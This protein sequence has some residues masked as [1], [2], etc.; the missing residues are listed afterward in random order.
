MYSEVTTAIKPQ[1][2]QACRNL[3]LILGD[4]LNFDSEIWQAFDTA[5][6]VVYMAEVF[7]ESTVTASSKMRTWLFLSAMRHFAQRLQAQQVRVD[8]RALDQGLTSFT[9]ALQAAI[10]LWQPTQISCVLAGDERVR[11]QLEQTAKQ[12]GLKINWL[13]DRHFITEPGEFAKWM[14]NKKQPRMEYWYRYLRKRHGI[15]M[16]EHNQPIG[17]AWNFD[18]QNRKPF[19]KSGPGLLDLGTFKVEHDHQS[20]TIIEQVKADI[21]QYLPSLAGHFGH[22][23]WPITREQALES[24]NDFIEHRLALFGDFQDA[25]WIGQDWLYHSLLSSSLNLKLLNPRE[26]IELA[27]KT[28]YAGRAPINAVEGFIRQVLGWREFIRGLYWQNREK[29]ESFNALEA[30]QNLPEFYW[31]GQTNMRCLSESLRPV[32]HQGYGHHIQRLMVTGLFAL[33]WQ[34]KPQQVHEWYLAMYVDAV[35]W[36]EIPNTIG[37]G[38]YADGGLVGSKP[39]IASGAYINRMSNYCK[40]CCYK[41]AESQNEQACPFTT[42]YWNFI[43]KHQALLAK[44]PRLAMQV[45]HWLNKP[46]I[47]Q[48]AIK[49]RSEWLFTNIEIV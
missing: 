20:Q 3:S 36:V 49:R 29:W 9:T 22:F 26:V 33:L 16:D 44:N 5:Q 34:V 10:D 4:Q 37:M 32:L 48:Q 40:H 8:Y 43:E 45:K 11:K 42:L 28:Y 30:S 1:K 17:G 41:P 15:L 14:A 19:S 27:E 31:H 2:Q 23:I 47:E 38:Q 25:M 18:K 13:A 39:Y 21:H 24:L 46:D 7:E 12:N 6:D 35:A